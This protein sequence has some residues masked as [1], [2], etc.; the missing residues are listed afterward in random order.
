MDSIYNELVSCPLFSA[1][2]AQE[3]AK[4]LTQDLFVIE[5][6]TKGEVVRMQGDK[7]EAL[8]VLLQGKLNARFHEY[9]GKT[10]LVETLSAPDPIAAGVLFSDVNYLPVT[11]EAVG[12]VR[13]ITI[14]KS[15]I[16]K[17]FQANA[18]M[19]RRFLLES[20]S[21]VVF[22]AEKVR[23]AGLANLRQKIS[24]Y[25]LRMRDQFNCNEFTIPYNREKMAELLSVARPS[26]SRELSKMVEA[27]LLELNGREVRILEPEELQDTLMSL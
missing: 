7:Y 2:T 1:F 12:D 10:M 15:G 25:L 8:M 27:G 20:G 23:L 18:E 4:L 22:L 5:T 17:L 21:K 24:D 6:F 13:I 26:L 14:K 16:L 3:L 19:L 11:T 9:S